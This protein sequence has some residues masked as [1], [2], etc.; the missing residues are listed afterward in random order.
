MVKRYSRP[1]VRYGRE[2]GVHHGFLG[3][4]G[5]PTISGYHLRRA[6]SKLSVLVVRQLKDID[7]N[8]FHKITG[9]LFVF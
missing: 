5:F 2:M 6:P 3:R 9:G 8:D 7:Q 4:D 1:N